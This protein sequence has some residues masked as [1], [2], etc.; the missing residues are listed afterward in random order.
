MLQS[1]YLLRLLNAQGSIVIYMTIIWVSITMKN[2]S[3]T[4]YFA[5]Y[6]HAE[7]NYFFVS[8]IPWVTTVFV[9]GPRVCS[10]FQTCTLLYS[11]HIL[12]TTL[13]QPFL[14]ISF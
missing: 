3:V 2:G 9:T 5:I 13:L 7:Y 8:Y 10:A 6:C 11:G 14:L 1:Y 12:V 4:G